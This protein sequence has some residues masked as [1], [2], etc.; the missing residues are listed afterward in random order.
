MITLILCLRPLRVPK[1][2]W[3]KILHDR[4]YE[5]STEMCRPES[6]ESIFAG[7]CRVGNLPLVKK[8]FRMSMRLSRGILAA[9]YAK[10]L[11][12]LEYLVEETRLNREIF[13]YCAARA[14]CTNLLDYLYSR[15]PVD[16]FGA[17]TSILT[18]ALRGG[19]VDFLIKAELRFEFDTEVLILAVKS[20]HL[21]AVQYVVE[22][23]PDRVDIR[24]TLYKAA[25]VAC[26][27][28]FIGI[29]DYLMNL[30]VE[31][32][33]E[34]MF[35]DDNYEEKIL[36][37]FMDDEEL[38]YFLIRYVNN[39]N[40]CLVEACLRGRLDRMEFFRVRGASYYPGCMRAAFY[41]GHVKVIEQ[42]LQYGL[43]YDEEDV[44]S[45]CWE[46]RLEVI[47]RFA[48]PEHFPEI[49]SRIYYESVDDRIIDYLLN[50]GA[51]K[52]TY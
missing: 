52:P 19:Q 15:Y 34:V 20:G 9:C 23:A 8:I 21:P 41:G 32:G 17:E 10:Q 40:D 27:K 43:T 25:E 11:E 39:Y 2:V 13:Y 7:A 49:M 47:A 51:K 4:R 50:A 44:I 46:N 30:I 36:N 22:T 37:E 3:F 31:Q 6:D 1:F 16:V 26:K 5:F 29:I 42:L 38:F 33:H 48:K 24:S 14:N 45:A 28:K 12:V 18:G 35:H